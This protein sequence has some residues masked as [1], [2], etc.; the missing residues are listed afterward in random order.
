MPIC[1]PS[2]LH[3]S[4]SCLCVL[5]LLMVALNIPKTIGIP[6]AYGLTWFMGVFVGKWMLGYKASYEEYYHESSD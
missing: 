4:T 1:E 6:I 3:R 2:K 5:I